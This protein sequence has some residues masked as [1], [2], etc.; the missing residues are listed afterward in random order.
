MADEIDL[1]KLTDRELL[2][3]A[4]QGVNSHSKRLDAH[5][6]DIKILRWLIGGMLGGFGLTKIPA[7]FGGGH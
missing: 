5:A 1:G 6:G 2:I 4:V 3:L 7:V